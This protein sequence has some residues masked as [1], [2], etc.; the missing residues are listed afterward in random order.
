MEVDMRLVLDRTSDAEDELLEPGYQKAYSCN[1]PYVSHEMFWDF[2]LDLMRTVAGNEQQLK[3]LQE[4]TANRTGDGEDSI[5][6][7][8][9]RREECIC[10]VRGQLH[11]VSQTDDGESTEI[12]IYQLA[13]E[14]DEQQERIQAVS[15]RECDELG[16]CQHAISFVLWLHNR[17]QPSACPS[18]RECFFRT[19]FVTGVE[20]LPPKPVLNKTKA[21]NFIREIVHGLQTEDID[22]PLRWN[23]SSGSK[24]FS[25]ISIHELIMVAIKNQYTADQFLEH[26][27]AVVASCGTTLADKVKFQPRCN[28]WFQELRYARITGAKVYDCV[29]LTVSPPVLY[30]LIL[31]CNKEIDAAMQRKKLNIR[32][33]LEKYTKTVYENPRITMNTSYPVVFDIPDGIC[34][35]HVV[36]IKCPRS[37]EHM[38]KYVTE[39]GS[40]NEKYY[41]EMQ[42]HM[43]LYGK[44]AGVV[45]VADPD[46]DSNSELYMHSF[47]LNKPFALKN[48]AK[49]MEYWK[50]NVYPELFNSWSE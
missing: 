42:V 1:V 3:A 26:A 24:K 30:E 40:I 21:K 16:C 32:Q 19:P 11:T 18:E 7:V 5:G 27:I 33:R 8:Q 44:A 12:K 46:F 38:K 50:N 6:F 37:V 17:N 31:G 28:A 45:C 23:F 39:D 20:Q 29:N 36:E 49:A 34:Q 43:L 35:S 48:L 47:N 4:L 10:T 15:C 22:C 9:L 41:L 25:N 14:V 2:I 13:V